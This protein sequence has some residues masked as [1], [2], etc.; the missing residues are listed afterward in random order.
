[1]QLQRRGLEGRGALWSNVGNLYLA[2]TIAYGIAYTLYY[3]IVCLSAHERAAPLA[4][5]HPDLDWLF[6]YLSLLIIFGLFFAGELR[7][8]SG[9]FLPGAYHAWASYL[10][11]EILAA[12]GLAYYLLHLRKAAAEPRASTPSVILSDPTL[13]RLGLHLGLLL[14]LGLSLKNGLR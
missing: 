3:R 8:W 10:Y 11:L 1:A 14:G 13:E 2:L 4:R 6:T 12:F 7:A 5:G 9:W